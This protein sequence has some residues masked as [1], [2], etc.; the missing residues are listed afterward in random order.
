MET[1]I[2][3]DLASAQSEMGAA[4]KNAKNPHFKKDYAD[5]SSVQEASMPSLNKYGFAVLQK[6]GQDEMG[7]YVDTIFAHKSGETISSRIY[8]LLQKKDMQGLGSAQ[9][10]ARRYGLMGLAGIAPADDDGNGSI[11]KNF[12][13]AAKIN[14]D[15]FLELRNLL[16]TSGVDEAVI[17]TAYGVRSLQEFY[18]NQFD[19]AVKRL[20]ATI[21]KNA[22][23]VAA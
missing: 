10:Y 11:D 15:Q 8:L 1:T 2:Y 6:F 20:S 4:L 5:L 18:V 17:L 9:T 7:Q 14:G 22:E 13:P 19:S 21:K 23:A 12:K 3:S 16:E